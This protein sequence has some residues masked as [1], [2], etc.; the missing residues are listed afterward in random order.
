L[1]FAAEQLKLGLCHLRLEISPDFVKLCACVQHKE[2]LEVFSTFPTVKRNQAGLAIG[3]N[4]FNQLFLPAT[5]RTPPA[6]IFDS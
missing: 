3:L 4:C 2:A 6:N 1:E 5:M